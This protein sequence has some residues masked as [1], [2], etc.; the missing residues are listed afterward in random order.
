LA[1]LDPAIITRSGKLYMDV[2]VDRGP[3]YGDT[4]TWSAGDPHPAG[5]PLVEVQQDVD[6]AK[7]YREFIELLSRSAA[8]ASVPAKK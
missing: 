1:W 4:L 8:R 5:T 2:S 3:T 7:F 6:A